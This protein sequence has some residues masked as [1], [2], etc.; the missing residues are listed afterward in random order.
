MCNKQITSIYEVE[1]LNVFIYKQTFNTY[2]INILHKYNCKVNSL[3]SG[4]V[5]LYFFYFFKKKKQERK[6]FR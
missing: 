2:Y 1:I 5:F 4:R 3:L 6:G